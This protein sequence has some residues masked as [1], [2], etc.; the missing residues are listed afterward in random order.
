[1]HHVNIHVKS[2]HSQLQVRQELAEEYEHVKDINN[3]LA[4]FKTD[5]PRGGQVISCDYMESPRYEEPTRDP[6]VWPPPTP[7]EHRYIS[8]SSWVMWHELCMLLGSAVS[9][10]LFQGWSRELELYIE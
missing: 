10:F 4:S 8:C 7:V 2:G 6:D 5:Q 3:T 1:L 9:V